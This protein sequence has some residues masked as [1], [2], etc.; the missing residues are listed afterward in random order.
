MLLSLYLL[1]LRLHRHRTRLTTPPLLCKQ[2]LWISDRQTSDC[3]D[4][5]RVQHQYHCVHQHRVSPD[6]QLEQVSLMSLVVSGRRLQQ[7]SE[8]AQVRQETGGWWRRLE[9]EDAEAA[10]QRTSETESGSAASLRSNTWLLITSCCRRWCS[11]W[12]CDAYRVWRRPETTCRWPRCS[13]PAAWIR[14]WD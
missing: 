10:P 6:L 12:M 9:L 2:S 8:T 13:A 5:W 11:R 7:V 14:L 4:L 3:D 1:E